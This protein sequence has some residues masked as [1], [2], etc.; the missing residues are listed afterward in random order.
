MEGKK[1]GRE[2]G[3]EAFSSQMCF[4]IFVAS[5]IV[6]QG[7]GFRLGVRV[8]GLEFIFV[9]SLSECQGAALYL[10]LYYRCHPVF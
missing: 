7:L 5:S 3:S 8:Q 9:A 10:S 6:C 4:T 2:E 1:A